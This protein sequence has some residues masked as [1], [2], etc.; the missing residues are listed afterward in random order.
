MQIWLLI[1]HYK[2][3]CQVL[4]SIV[5][6][7]AVHLLCNPSENPHLQ[8]ISQCFHLKAASLCAGESV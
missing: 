4:L 6:T 1:V 8:L 7:D 5:E 3:K 2:S